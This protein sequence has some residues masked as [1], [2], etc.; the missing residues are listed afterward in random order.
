MIYYFVLEN[1][2][3][4]IRNNFYSQLCLITKSP[5]NIE[6]LVKSLDSLAL[7]SVSAKTESECEAVIDLFYKLISVSAESRMVKNAGAGYWDADIPNFSFL[8]EKKVV[9]E[10]GTNACRISK[11]AESIRKN[12][13]LEGGNPVP[14]FS[15]DKKPAG[16]VKKVVSFDE[17][18]LTKLGG[19]KEECIDVSQGD[20]QTV[21]SRL[22]TQ[23]QGKGYYFELLGILDGIL[24]YLKRSDLSIDDL[25][26]VEQWLQDLGKLTPY[27]ITRSLEAP[28][29]IEWPPFEAISS[30]KVTKFSDLVVL[31]FGNVYA[32]LLDMLKRRYPLTTKEHLKNFDFECFA[33]YSVSLQSTL[34]LKEY[35]S[36]QPQKFFYLLLKLI[37]N[38]QLF[39]MKTLCKWDMSNI[40]NARDDRGLT[41]LHHALQD[42]TFIDL[43]EYLLDKGASVFVEHEPGKCAL[44][45]YSTMENY[46]KY[47][48]KKLCKKGRNEIGL[49]SVCLTPSTISTLEQI[50]HKIMLFSQV[51]NL[52]SR[53]K[54]WL[55]EEIEHTL[56]KCKDFNCKIPEEQV[57]ALKGIKA[58]LSKK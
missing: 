18:N 1:F 47:L 43:A 4:P 17:A 39:R 58:N 54:K 25:V 40:I 45:F 52:R 8:V 23:F 53:D 42:D 3:E 5:S 11:A 29:P 51:E 16:S 27:T 46:D 13:K 34:L 57:K 2:M 44:G 50:T 12:M 56:K 21:R 6:I 38:D 28:E 37:H 26:Q 9:L 31:S 19:S 55:I 10:E 32:K 15:P 30:R 35:F 33:L 41:P 36:D 14:S 22:S 48:F 24:R 20:V 49:L 7:L